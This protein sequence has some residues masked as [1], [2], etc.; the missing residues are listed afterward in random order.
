MTSGVVLLLGKT[1][2]WFAIPLV[3]AVWDLRNLR[4]DREALA[5]REAAATANQ[6]SVESS[7]SSQG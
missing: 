1:V 6:S 7:R 4:R 3:I 2:L 5:R